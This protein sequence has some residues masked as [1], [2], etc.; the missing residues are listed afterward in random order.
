MQ[1]DER[2]NADKGQ[3][4]TLIDNR[5]DIYRFQTSEVAPSAPDT[6]H[7]SL[8]FGAVSESNRGR[9]LISYPTNIQEKM[10]DIK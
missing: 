6:K 3:I 4:W 10:V 7:F 5:L 2:F 1:A 8:I 9:W